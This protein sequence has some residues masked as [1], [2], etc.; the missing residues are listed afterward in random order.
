MPRIV[1]IIERKSIE[2]ERLKF[3]TMGFFPC[4]APDPSVRPACCHDHKKEA[5]QRLGVQTKSN[6]S[7]LAPFFPLLPT[8][9]ISPTPFHDPYADEVVVYALEEQHGRFFSPIKF[10]RSLPP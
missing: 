10:S 7:L 3:D 8:P 5:Y 6:V 2:C 9:F 4:F 1:K